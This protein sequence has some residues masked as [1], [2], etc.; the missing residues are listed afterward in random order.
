MLQDHTKKTSQTGK[1]VLRYS[2][3]K[4]EQFDW[5]KPCWARNREPEVGRTCGRRRIIHY[6]RIYHWNKI[7]GHLMIRFR[8]EVPNLMFGPIVGPLCPNTQE[9]ECSVKI[10]PC[11]WSLLSI[12]EPHAKRQKKLMVENMRTCVKDGRMD[13]RT[14]GQMDRPEFTGPF[15]K[16]GVQ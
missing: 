10:R 2:K 3:S 12:P 7:I 5:F 8:T 6:H 9:R 1:P 14:R 15:R 16:A 11:H 4:S 13:G